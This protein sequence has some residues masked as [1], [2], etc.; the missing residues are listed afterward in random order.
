[1]NGEAI[2]VHPY[3]IQ[4]A[5]FSI[6]WESVLII[7][8]VI[9]S[10]AMAWYL[11]KPKGEAYR[12]ALLDLC[13]WLLPA[14]VIGARA[15]EV[16]WTWESYKEAPLQIFAAWD[17]GMSI[18]GA[19]LFGGIAAILFARRRG[20]RVWELLDLLAPAALVGQAIGR[21]GCFLS[22]DSWG[23]PVEAVSW[24]PQALG[25]VYSPDSP[26]VHAHGLT[27][28]IPAELMEAGADIVILGL[29]LIAWQG[30]RRPGQIALAYAAAYSLA[31]FL[32]EFLRDDSLMLGPFKVA[33]LLSVLV[34]LVVVPFWFRRGRAAKQVND[35]A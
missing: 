22:G 30:R 15:W 1:M 23:K 9:L 27:P 2:L 31:R 11:A 29:L 32:L 8:G 35:V 24:W 25:V 17:G 6:R 13:F 20:L 3:F 10:F 21:I 16:L 19:L 34:I 26:A 5:S 28:L 7:I 33:Q 12:D 4:T 18:Q 14:G